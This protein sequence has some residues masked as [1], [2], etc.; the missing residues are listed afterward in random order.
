MNEPE[1]FLFSIFFFCRFLH[2]KYMGKLCF[3]SVN[4]TNFAIKK[5]LIQIHV[6]RILEKLVYGWFFIIFHRL[7]IYI[8]IYIISKFVILQMV[9]LGQFFKQ[10]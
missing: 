5:F 7:F 4:L 3:S 8:Y 9:I 2:K 1:K 10:L 6:T